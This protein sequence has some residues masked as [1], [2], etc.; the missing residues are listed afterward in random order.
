LR[1]QLESLLADVSRSLGD[2]TEHPE[3]SAHFIRT[4]VKRLQSLS[5]LVPRG[6]AW[7]KIFL[8][9]CRDL[10]DLFAE[11]RDA[12]I[13]R[14]LGEKYAPGDNSL[15]RTAPTPDLSAASDLVAKSVRTLGD[16]QGWNTIKRREILQRAGKTY[17]AARNL[18]KKARRKHASETDFHNW[19][20]LVKR[21]LY[22]CEFLDVRK[23][24]GRKL[25]QLGE[26]LGELQDVCMTQDWLTGRGLSIDPVKIPQTKKRL[27]SKALRLGRDVFRPKTLGLI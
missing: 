18:G 26:A 14:E 1:G 10:K 17:S 8:P 11:V 25:A 6:R 4:R 12:T 15:L 7:R 23:V 9:L 13:V 24:K 16:Y 19:R 22:Q 2:F 3:E 20:R 5:R 27:Q 21:L